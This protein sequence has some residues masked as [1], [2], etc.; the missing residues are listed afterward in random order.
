VRASDLYLNATNV[1]G[2]ADVAYIKQEEDE[3]GY[4]VEARRR[5]D[6]EAFYSATAELLNCQEVRDEFERYCACVCSL[7]AWA[8][9]KQ[10]CRSAACFLEDVTCTGLQD[11]VAF[12]ESASRGWA[13]ALYSLPLKQGDRIITSAADYGSNFISFL[14]VTVGC[15][16]AS[17]SLRARARALTLAG[18]HL[19]TDRQGKFVCGGLCFKRNLPMG[20]RRRREFRPD[21]TAHRRGN[22][23]TRQS[24]ISTFFPTLDVSGRSRH[25]LQNCTK[26]I[27][28]GTRGYSRKTQP[29]KS[30]LIEKHIQKNTKESNLFLPTPPPYQVG[31]RHMGLRDSCH[32]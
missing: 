7:A 22:A 30:L 14:Q 13:L 17:L 8:C 24:Q 6:L 19:L 12:V 11:E 5:G 29:R 20:A 16:V 18:C 32:G 15:A 21:A 27:R 1:Y 2:T 3:G 4:E 31:E 9:L 28:S 26:S 10:L 25:I 23:N